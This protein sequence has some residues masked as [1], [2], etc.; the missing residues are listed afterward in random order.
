MRTA[1]TQKNLLQRYLP[2]LEW[3][4]RYNRAWL[5]GDLIAGLSVWALTVP[6]SLADAV[7]A[8]VPVQH[9][10]Y[11]AVIACLVYAVFASSRQVITGPAAPI[12]A[13]AG[14]AVLAVADRGSPEA[15][16]L[17]AAIALLAG[18]LYIT[19]ALLKMG[20]I[21]NFLSA[22]V[23]TGFV[24]GV[25]IALVVSQLH[26]ISGTAET[27]ANTWQ[28]LANWIQGLPGISL[29]DSSTGLLLQFK[30]SVKALLFLY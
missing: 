23:L 13:I 4:P 15:V 6:A 8:G 25:G 10:L 1:R 18:V 21:S 5:A 3:L 17:V 26:T 12:A 29:P 20:W 11:A 7:I 30:Q 14:A 27:G 9:G 24:F 28:K 2:I 16:Q 19:F 22:S